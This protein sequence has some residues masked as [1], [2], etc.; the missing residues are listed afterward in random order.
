[1]LVNIHSDKMSLKYGSTS[2]VG[3]EMICPK[4]KF[5]R[6]NLLLLLILLAIFT[7]VQKSYAQEEATAYCKEK[8]TGYKTDNKTGKFLDN[9]LNATAGTWMT[10]RIWGLIN[11]CKAT[12]KPTNT[13]NTK[14]ISDKKNKEQEVQNQK[15]VLQNKTAEYE[16]I[17]S[18]DEFEARARTANETDQKRIAAL[19][20]EKQKQRQDEIERFAVLELDKKLKKQEAE[21]NA[22]AA[23]EAEI[24]RLAAIE[25]ERQTQKEAVAARVAQIEA[26]KIRRKELDEAREK[27]EKEKEIERLATLEIEKKKIREQLA[28]KAKVDALRVAALEAEN[29][30]QKEEAEA[31]AK[32]QRLLELENE[33]KKLRGETT[34][35]KPAVQSR[36]DV[37]KNENDP[38][39]VFEGTWVSV[40]PPV[41]YLIFN[42]VALGIRQVSLPNIGQGNI[43]LSDGSHGSNFQISAA[44]LNCFYFVTFTNNRQKMVME[45]KAGENLCLQSSVLEKAE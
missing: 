38:L 35:P 14:E 8:V 30:R 5:F 21:E 23:K 36:Q 43:R 2:I 3:F 25:N 42:K 32:A 17:K 22:K 16:K 37:A 15:N 1:M 28:E 26:E 27:I 19:E 34:Q 45:L 40:N 29:Q 9:Q 4:L 6:Y 12:Y 20:I 7:N 31:R 39:Y 24:A 33:L 18:R 44:N 41:F 10:F 11:N 13:S